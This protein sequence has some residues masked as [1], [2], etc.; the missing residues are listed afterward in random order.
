MMMAKPVA[1]IRNAR[2]GLP[3]ISEVIEKPMMQATSAS[4]PVLCQADNPSVSAIAFINVNG[5]FDKMYPHFIS[6][7]KFNAVHGVV[8]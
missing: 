8:Q 1:N 6:G 3:A 5:S 4:N 7:L 2:I